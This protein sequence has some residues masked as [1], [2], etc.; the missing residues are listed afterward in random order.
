MTQR[1]K[2]YAEVFAVF[3]LVALFTKV[4]LTGAFVIAPYVAVIAVIACLRI[5]YLK[6]RNPLNLS[7]ARFGRQ[8]AVASALFFIT[9]MAF[10]VLPVFYLGFSPVYLLQYRV[11]SVGRFVFLFIQLFLF[12]GVGEEI[13]FRG[14]IM[15]RLLALPNKNRAETGVTAAVIS[16]G[17]FS[18]AHFRPGGD[19]SQLVVA[20]ITGLL[21]GAARL[22]I[23][24]CG[25]LTTGMA[26]GAHDSLLLVLGNVML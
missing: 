22:K 3:A 15:E 13:I 14:Y 12:S 24:G 23:K 5:F 6:E 16:A 4:R 2:I 9:S 19:R 1:I 18:L 17:L 25:A 10:T 7:L 8:L 20:F 11:R 21:Y 26:H